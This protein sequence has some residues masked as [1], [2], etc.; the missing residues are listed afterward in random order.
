[1]ERFVM[2]PPPERLAPEPRRVLARAGCPKSA[3]NSL[4][5][6]ATF[7]I[8][9]LLALARPAAFSADLPVLS[10]DENTI[11]LEG[12]TIRSSDMAKK[13]SG[14]SFL[15][16]FLATIGPGPEESC[17]ALSESGRL[18]EALLL[19]AAASEMVELLLRSAHRQ[20]SLRMSGFI[21]TARYAP[22]YGDFSLSHQ[23][24][25][26]DALGGDSTGVMV[27]KDSYMLVPQK[28]T[29]GVVGWRKQGR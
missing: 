25:I 13:L 20:A 2:N 6:P 12:L 27:M 9:R 11:E 16:I 15:T 23:A 21:G 19:D 17:R 28:S 18:T 10:S 22:G 1:M 8:E 4:L 14:S 5:K 7:A 3:G 24:F 29:T 26:V